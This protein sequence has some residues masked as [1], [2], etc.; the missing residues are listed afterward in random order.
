MPK[1]RVAFIATAMIA[2]VCVP[3]AFLAKPSPRI[4]LHFLGTASYGQAMAVLFEVRNRPPNFHLVP[5]AK[6]EPIEGA[7]WKELKG[8]FVMAGVAD[9]PTNFIFSCVID[10]QVHAG[11][12]RLVTQYERTL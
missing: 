7:T 5:S 11:R 8:G 9:G 12:L 4:E 6:L 10:R 3:F 1:R 2:L